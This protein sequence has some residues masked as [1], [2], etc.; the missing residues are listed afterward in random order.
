MN[1]VSTKSRDTCEYSKLRE[2]THVNTVR[3][4]TE[5]HLNTVSTKSR[6]THEYSKY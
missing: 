5:T 2:E 3:L 1:T 6:D 4:R